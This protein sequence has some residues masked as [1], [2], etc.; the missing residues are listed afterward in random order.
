MFQPE[1]GRPSYGTTDS[2]GN[3]SLNYLEGTPGAVVGQHKVRIRTEIPGE[4]GAP[5]QE[6]E[7][8]PKRYHDETELVE[9]VQPGGS[10]INFTLTT[11]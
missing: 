8:L 3:Y 1:T 2:S 6:K 11:K 7:R 5:V 10:E 4:D 9:V